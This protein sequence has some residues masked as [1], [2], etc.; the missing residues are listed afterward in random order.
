TSLFAPSPLASTPL[1]SASALFKVFTL[2]KAKAAANA[3]TAGGTPD[4]QAGSTPTTAGNADQATG[5][6]GAGESA[7]GLA[8]HDQAPASSRLPVVMVS[9]L[10]IL[11]VLGALVVLRR[12]RSAVVRTA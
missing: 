6:A 2:M 5:P 4:A 11:A 8:A 10:L 1:A 9:V 3:E 7:A 12:S